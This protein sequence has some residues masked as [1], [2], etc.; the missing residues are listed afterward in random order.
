MEV[1]TDGDN[2]DVT[3]S[4]CMPLRLLSPLLMADSDGAGD[5]DGGNDDSNDVDDDGNTGLDND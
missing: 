4:L 5:G 2:I 1:D 3:V